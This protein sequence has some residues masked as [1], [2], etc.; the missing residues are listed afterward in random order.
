M[1]R[2]KDEGDWVVVAEVMGMMEAEIIA[3]LLRTAEIPCHLHQEGI[4]A[5][6]GVSAGPMGFIKVLVPSQFADDAF[7]LLDDDEPDPADLIDGPTI[8]F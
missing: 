5:A 7:A 6:F 1:L 8:D 2:R 4:G 3:G